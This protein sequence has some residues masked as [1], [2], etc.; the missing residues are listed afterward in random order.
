MWLL[1]IMAGIA[2]VVSFVRRRDN[3]FSIASVRCSTLLP[4]VDSAKARRDLGW[5]PAP[6]EQSLAAAVEYYLAHP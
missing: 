1:Y 3:R 4:N 6:I 2:D 5:Q